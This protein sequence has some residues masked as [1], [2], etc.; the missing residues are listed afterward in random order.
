LNKSDAEMVVCSVAGCS[1]GAQ[2]ADIPV[3]PTYTNILSMQV[4]VTLEIY[5]HRPIPQ[6][7]YINNLKC[8]FDT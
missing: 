8:S 7:R 1:I 6:Y 4:Y 3:Y 2:T 5:T